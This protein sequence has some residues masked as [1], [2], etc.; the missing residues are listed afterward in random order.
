MWLHFIYS[1]YHNMFYVWSKIII[2][3]CTVGVVHQYLYDS[4]CMKV[5]PSD[6]MDHILSW[7]ESNHFKW[8]H[9]H[10]PPLLFCCCCCVTLTLLLS[11][12]DL[13]TD[14]E[15]SIS[16]VIINFRTSLKTYL[17][18][19]TLGYSNPLADIGCC[20]WLKKQFFFCCWPLHWLTGEYS[21]RGE[22]GRERGNCMCMCVCVCLC[23]CVCVCM[24]M[25]GRVRNT[26]SM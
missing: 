18:L 22:T 25:R 21:G 3:S 12:H 15:L 17:L 11:E 19:P 8:S 14:T 7:I 1:L 5:L 13:Y 23:M 24:W 20:T 4:T 2:M 10:T 26:V 16:L 9:T 6:G